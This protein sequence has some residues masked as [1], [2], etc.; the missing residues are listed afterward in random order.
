M[1]KCVKFVGIATAL[2]AALLLGGCN[3]EKNITH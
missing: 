3:E 2:T 1:N